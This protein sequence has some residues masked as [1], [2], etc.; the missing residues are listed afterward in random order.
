ML[1]LKNHLII[2]SC[3]VSLLPVLSRQRF[4]WDFVKW[5]L[6]TLVWVG[7]CRFGCDYA[8]LWREMA[9]IVLK[10]QFNLLHK[11]Y[12]RPSQLDVSALSPSNTCRDK[13]SGVFRSDLS[14]FLHAT[15][16]DLQTIIWGNN[17]IARSPHCM[18]DE[19]FPCYIKGSWITSDEE[20]YPCGVNTANLKGGIFDLDIPPSVAKLNAAPA[21]AWLKMPNLTSASRTW[22]SLLDQ[23]WKLPWGRI[24]L[25]VE[26]SVGVAVAI[27]LRP[28]SVRWARTGLDD[29]SFK[30]VSEA[31]TING[32]LCDW[33]SLC[34]CSC[35]SKWVRNRWLASRVAIKATADASWKL[36]SST[37]LLTLS[38]NWNCALHCWRLLKNKIVH[39]TADASLKPKSSTPT[40]DDLTL[41]G[42]KQITTATPTT[43][44]T[45]SVWYGL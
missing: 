24:T 10:L 16:K 3:V 9:E 28:I 26:F 41:I 25:A 43:N 23:P 33:D 44:S 5:S 37:S 1:G 30:E 4:Y 21:K 17:R 27:R 14:N 42:R 8:G 34:R 20:E 18:A 19:C 40:W 45:T 12:E 11:T 38:W 32:R 31:T 15:W 29:F 13:L 39:S 6:I 36:K 7:L 22:R 2:W 35:I